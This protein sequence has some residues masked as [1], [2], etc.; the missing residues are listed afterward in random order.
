MRDIEAILATLDPKTRAN[1]IDAVNYTP[2]RRKT[3]SVGINLAVGGGFGYGRQVMIW[4][5]KSAGKSTFC[6]QMIADAQKDGEAVAWIDAE[7]SWDT[8]W[9]ERFGVDASRVIVSRTKTISGATKEIEKLMAAKVDIIVVD[10]ISSLLPSM[11]F[12]DK[13]ELKLVE[14][15]K[16]I[17]QQAREIGIATNMWNYAN[18]GDTLL[19]LI[20]QARNKFGAT[21]ASFIPTGGEAVKFNSSQSIK[22]WSSSAD[23]YAIKGEVRNGNQI[24]EKKVGRPVNW[25]VDYNKLGPALESGSY[26]FYYQGDHIGVDTIGELLDYAVAYN[27]VEK[28]GAWYTIE[29]ERFQGRHKAVAFLRDNPGLVGEIENALFES[30]DA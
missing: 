2:R 21:H 17:G 28:G 3:P 24:F 13:G 4:G 18:T 23:A 27:V 6:L 7:N 20:S 8:P 11:Y 10:S 16:Q 30:P 12:E 29:G 22:L 1:F 9:A 26:D 19:V 5:N 25:L 15:S 14:N